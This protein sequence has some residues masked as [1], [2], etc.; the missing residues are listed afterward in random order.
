GM[1]LDD[2]KK[3]IGWQDGKEAWWQREHSAPSPAAAGEGRVRVPG[4]A[5]LNSKRRGKAITCVI[6]G[7]VTPS[8]STASV[9]LNE[10]GS[11]NVLTSSVEMGQGAKTVLA[12]IAAEAASLPLAQVSVS[13]P[14]TD[15]TPYEQQTSSSRTTFSMGSA[16]GLA[17][18]D[19][20]RQLLELAAEQLEASPDDLAA[21]DG[22]VVVKGAPE[23]GLSY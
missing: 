10:D 12:Q 14:D 19:V 7:S 9:K 20:K 18:D 21:R 16:V 8:T 23:R 11:L 5:E 17:V 2:V 1:L 3:A 6:K 15:S 22:R 4:G 13:E